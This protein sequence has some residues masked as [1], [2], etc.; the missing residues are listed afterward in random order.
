M[1]PKFSTLAVRAGEGRD[2]ATNA[3]NTPIYQTAT[4]SFE[5]AEEMIGAI[6]EPL[7]HY[8][9]SRTSNP[10]T[11]ALEKKLA[12][13][14]GAEE[15]LATASG[16]AA[17]AIAVMI[18][19]QAG[20]HV[21]VDE[22]LF[23]ISR[24]FFTQDCP[25]MGLEVSFVDVRRMETV[26]SALRPNTRALFT[27]TLT[28]PNMLVAD[29]SGLAEFCRAHGLR[30]IVDNTFMSPYLLRPLEHGADLV[31]HSA[32]KYLSGH[33]DTVAGVLAGSRD[34]M[35][36]ARL[37]LD[38]F[39]Q[40]PSPLNSWLLMRGVRTLPMRMR[41]HSANATALARVLE[42]HPKVEWIRYPGLESHPQHALAARQFGAGFG[43]MFAFKVRGGTL[44]MNRFCNALQMCDLGVSLGDVFTLVY[45]KPKN[46][47][48]IRVSVGCEDI[49]DILADFE[50]ALEQL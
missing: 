16:M 42:P 11:A 38:S 18:S 5:R 33:G 9:Y 19:A 40:C 28:N 49:E 12:A 43:G 2:P 50:Q 13:L 37:K 20:D 47:N 22:D 27:E 41:Q 31:L 35:R 26:R 8:F 36:R 45:P 21:L 44:E 15:S 24:E 30:L 10:T 14:E 23:V 3:H 1:K 32:T 25:A 29:I 6:A 39:G 34:E 46:G 4:F 17:V 48:L 7:D